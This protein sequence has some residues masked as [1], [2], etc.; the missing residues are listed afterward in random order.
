MKMS[1]ERSWTFVLSRD[2]K[3]HIYI[4]FGYG[5]TGKAGVKLKSNFQCK[6]S[7]RKGQTYV[8]CSPKGL[9][10]LNMGRKKIPPTRVL[11]KDDHANLCHIWW[12]AM[13]KL[14][15]WG[16][17]RF[18]LGKKLFWKIFKNQGGL[19]YFQTQTDSWAKFDRSRL[20][21]QQCNASLLEILFL[22]RFVFNHLSRSL[23]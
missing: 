15:L 7:F 5:G 20:F 3:L 11:W 18:S 10:Q 23:R 17:R 16:L 21:E 6:K 13:F 22:L 4:T 9:I 8:L 12:S 14:G 19:D 2:W 1:R